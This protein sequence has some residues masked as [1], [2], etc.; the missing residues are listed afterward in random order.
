[1][2]PDRSLPQAEAPVMWELWRIAT[3]SAKVGIGKTTIYS[4]VQRG[5]F[6]A[7]RKVGGSVAWL[8]ADVI[9]WMAS[10]PP[11]DI[12]AGVGEN[13]KRENGAE[14]IG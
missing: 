4:L 6:P 8:S 7:P 10:L 11:A 13:D 2:T 12:G 3:V 5:K 9:A 1:M 14:S